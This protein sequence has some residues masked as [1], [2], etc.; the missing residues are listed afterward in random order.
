MGISGKSNS[1][2]TGQ[3]LRCCRAHLD[4]EFFHNDW[5]RLAHAV[6]AADGLRLQGGVEGGLHEEDMVGGRQIDAD[7]AA[8]HAEQEDCGGRVLLEGLNCLR[9]SPGLPQPS[10]WL[11][12][13]SL[14]W[15]CLSDDLIVDLPMDACRCAGMHLLD[16][17]T[18]KRPSAI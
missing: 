3:A 1:Y 15:I 12:L 9:I 11:A 2:G 13:A 18:N 7:G 4:V 10:P 17:M 5:P 14:V 6:R 16:G 8:A